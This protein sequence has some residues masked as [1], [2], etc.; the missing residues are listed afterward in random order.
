MSVW[1]MRLPGG[2]SPAGLA[3]VFWLLAACLVVSGT[4]DA[5][6]WSLAQW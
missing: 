6:L 5:A 4:I 2:W 3:L 1:R